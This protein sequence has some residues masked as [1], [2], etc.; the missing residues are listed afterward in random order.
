MN[1]INPVRAAAVLAHM[2]LAGLALTSQQA[3]ASTDNKIAAG[4][5]TPND[6]HSITFETKNRDLYKVTVENRRYARVEAI[7]KEGKVRVEA[8]LDALS[9]ILIDVPGHIFEGLHIEQV[10]PLDK[11]VTPPSV[12]SLLDPDNSALRYTAEEGFLTFDGTDPMPRYTCPAEVN[13]AL[14]VGGQG[15]VLS[16]TSPQ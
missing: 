10:T 1:F 5:L 15:P 13:R 2:A 16:T 9:P 3:A 6:A 4:C 7:I 8:S 12:R 14:L 11:S